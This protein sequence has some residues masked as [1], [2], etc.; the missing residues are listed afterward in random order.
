MSRLA[1]LQIFY[2]VTAFSAPSPVLARTSSSAK[3]ASAAA[4]APQECAEDRAEKT[5]RNAEDAGILQ[6][7]NRR[8]L[9]QMAGRAATVGGID[10]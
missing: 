8:P 9:D 10:P 2:S 1:V 3:R 4:L 5:E 6:R 7:E